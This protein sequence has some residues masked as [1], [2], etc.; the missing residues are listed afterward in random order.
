[1]CKSKLG[2]GVLDAYSPVRIVRELKEKKF[3]TVRQPMLPGYIIIATDYDLPS[4]SSFIAGMSASSYGL[5][6]NLDKSYE[7]KG[8]D[9]VYAEWISRFEGVITESKV[10][11]EKNLEEGTQIVVLSGP[12]KELKGRIIR[13]YKKTRVLVEIPFLNEI[14]RINLPVE[15]VEETEDL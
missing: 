11:V 2:E 6:R 8:D 10:K 4:I 15:V 1:M 9:R 7:L 14:R 12:M 13:L 3:R 5:I